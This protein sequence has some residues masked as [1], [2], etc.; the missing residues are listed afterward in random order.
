MTDELQ[1]I[2]RNKINW[3][4]RACM[5]SS[6]KDRFTV[7]FEDIYFFTKS[8]KYYFEQQTERTLTYDLNLRDRDTTKLNNTP[9]RT[10]MAGL[11]TNAYETRNMRTTWDIP[12]EPSGSDHYAAYPTKLVERM[13]RAGCPEGGLVYDPFGGTATTAVTAHKLGRNWI[14]SEL[15]PK[16][17]EIAERRMEPMLNQLSLI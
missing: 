13:I 4:K 12:F 14:C 7:D 2:Q 8:P 5:P 3:W 11:N 10:R 17:V 16:Y 15:Q 6:A 9:G 1:M